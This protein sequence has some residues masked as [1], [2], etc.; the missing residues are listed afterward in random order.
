[1]CE[2]PYAIRVRGGGTFDKREVEMSMLRG[3]ALAAILG[4]ALAGCSQT[5]VKEGL[6]LRDDVPESQPRGFVEFRLD[7]DIRNAPAFK[8]SGSVWIEW[9]KVWADSAIKRRPFD[10]TAKQAVRR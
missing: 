4:F 10:L 1:L 7:P 3:V 5:Q 9:E 6:Y 2:S 8:D